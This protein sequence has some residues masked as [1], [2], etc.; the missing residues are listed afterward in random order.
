MRSAGTSGHP[1]EIDGSKSARNDEGYAASANCT[2]II[3]AIIISRLQSGALNQ[4]ST[5]SIFS[6]ATY[7]TNGPRFGPSG[8]IVM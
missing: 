3:P 4:K 2:R 8:S 5:A 1:H 6:V 7:S